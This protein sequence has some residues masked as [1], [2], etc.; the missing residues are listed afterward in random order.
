METKDGPTPVLEWRSLLLCRGC[1]LAE[2]AILAAEL[3]VL[4][5]GACEAGEGILPVLFPPTASRR[6][7]A[8]E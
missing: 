3:E 6:R 2:D 8:E 4:G 7:V 5:L 1:R